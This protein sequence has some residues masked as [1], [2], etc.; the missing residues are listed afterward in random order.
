MSPKVLMSLALVTSLAGCASV[1]KAD[2]QSKAAREFD[3]QKQAV[4]CFVGMKNLPDE[5]K[6]KTDTEKAELIAQ[7]D[8]LKA[9][10]AAKEREGA[11]LA[12]ADLA[13]KDK[14]RAELARQLEA[15]NA[16]ATGTGNEK[17]DLARQLEASRTTLTLSGE[18]KSNLARQLAAAQADLAAKENERAEFAR[19]LE[20]LKAQPTTAPAAKVVLKEQELFDSG[21]ATLKPEGIKVV[22]K[23]AET[24]KDYPDTV[25]HSEGHTDN[26]PISTGRFPSNWELSSAR[27]TA[28]IRTLQKQGISPERLIAI[29]YGDT[30]PAVPNADAESRAKNRRVEIIVVPAPATTA[31]IH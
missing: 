2:W 7:I 6:P 4:C 3:T 10:L 12:A 14:E 13:A 23:L 24:L 1:D 22:R 8:E 17:S 16:N 20:A 27:A 11:N 25:I 29:G 18:E 15:L 9:A 30:R 26:K 28:V 5:S 19:Q 31:G 21:S